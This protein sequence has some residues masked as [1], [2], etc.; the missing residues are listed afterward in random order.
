MKPTKGKLF[1]DGK[2]IGKEINPNLWKGTVGYVPQE[3]N[4][5]DD[6]LRNN[7][8]FGVENCLIDD[9]KVWKSLSDANLFDFA[10][11]LPLGLNTNMGEKG[12]RLSGGQRQRVGIA[13]ALYKNPNLVV[14]D[15]ATSSL[16]IET[17]KSIMDTIYKL[18]KDKTFIMVA[19]RLS[20]IEKCDVVY[21]I[22][23]GQVVD[24]GSF[25]KV[26]KGLRLKKF[27]N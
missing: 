26:M 4:L 22:E 6:S 23:K 7:V 24:C 27:I 18:K 16:D 3:I 2:E 10:K 19:H 13:R 11:D 9:E 20:T 15:E 21:K 14:F 1:I 5:G 25:E 17:E 12:V 8:A